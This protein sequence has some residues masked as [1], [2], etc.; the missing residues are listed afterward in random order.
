MVYDV[1]IIGGGAS[2]LFAASLLKVNKGLILE[3]NKSVGTKLL[4]SGNG[5]CNITHGGNIKDY[6]DKYGDK[7]KIIRSC[8]YKNN[9]I[10]LINHLE[11]LGVP[12][13]ERKDGKVFPVSMKA[14]DVKVAMVKAAKKN[15][16]DIKTGA[17]VTAVESASFITQTRDKSDVNNLSHKVTQNDSNVKYIDDDIITVEAS[18]IGDGIEKYKTKNV[19]I[20]PGGAS[21]PSTGS[22]GSFINVLKKIKPTAIIRPLKPAL[23][24]IYVENYAFSEMSGI[25]FDKAGITIY[26]NARSITNPKTI[27]KEGSLLLTHKCFSGPL[28][29]DSSRYIE[30]GDR[31]TINYCNG[32]SAERLVSEL[33]KAA[34]GSSKSVVTIVLDV[35]T[36]AGYTMPQRFVSAVINEVFLDAPKNKENNRRATELSKELLVKIAKAFTE[37]PFIVSGLGSFREAMC[38]SGG[39]DLSEVDLKT[40]EW[41]PNIYVIGEVLDVDGDT[42][43]YNLQFAFSSAAAAIS[44]IRL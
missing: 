6:I 20:A 18:L 17:Y 22:D 37:M 31:I 2:G 15:G 4:M 36:N 7:G 24:P 10:A 25:S 33:K 32:F 41:I 16:F 26:K 42:G 35:F 5:Q 40:M 28:I 29:I 34:V 3:R 43:G 14:T 19:I 21:Y 30:T 11:S 38:T 44:N 9:N 13:Y 12:L 39:L 8:L 1:I 23:V 27:S